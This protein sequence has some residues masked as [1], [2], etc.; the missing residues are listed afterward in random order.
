MVDKVK[1][2]SLSIQ[3]RRKTIHFKLEFSYHYFDNI[4]TIS[5]YRANNLKQCRFERILNLSGRWSRYQNKHHLSP[6][7]GRIKK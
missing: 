1:K 6:T 7:F 2:N 4:L 5:Y 3:F